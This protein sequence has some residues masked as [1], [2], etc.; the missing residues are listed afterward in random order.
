MGTSG[1]GSVRGMK[2]VEEDGVGEEDEEGE[3]RI[4]RIV[5]RKVCEEKRFKE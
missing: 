1:K 3:G 2:E 4:M 5:K